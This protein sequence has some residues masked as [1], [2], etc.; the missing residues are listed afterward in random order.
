MSEPCCD[1]CG[2]NL[3]QFLVQ[4]KVCG[5]WF[6]NQVHHGESD[7]YHHIRAEKHKSFY[8]PF[9][10]IGISTPEC[11]LCGKKDCTTLCIV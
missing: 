6:C 8:F 3:K 7:A 5:K 2:L 1:I 11:A 9:N 10:N 4:C